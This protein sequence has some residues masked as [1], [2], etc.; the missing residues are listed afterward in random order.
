MLTRVFAVVAVIVPALFAGAQV[1]PPLNQT[2]ADL[3]GTMLN[4]WHD[5]AAKA[6]E[7]RYFKHFLPNAV[8]MGTDIKERWTAKEFREWAQPYFKRG[9]AW[10][11]TPHDRHIDFST[12]MQTGWFDELLDTPNL[13]TARGS[14]VVRFTGEEWKIAQYNLSVP[15]PNEILDKVVKMIREGP[16]AQGAPAP[17]P[18]RPAL[19]L[20][21]MTFNIRYANPDDGENRWENRR[22]FLA[23]VIR[24]GHYDVVG[25]QEALHA[26][27]SDLEHALPEFDRVGVGRDDGKQ[28]GEHAAIL[29]RKDRFR[30]L[31]EGTFWF[32]DTPQA[33]GS[34]AWG[35]NVTRVCTWARLAERHTPHGGEPRSFYIYNVHLDQESQP[36]REKSVTLLLDRIAARSVPTPVI[37]TGDFNAGEDNVIIQRMTGETGPQNQHPGA[38][39]L[40]V[41]SFRIAHPDEHTVGTFHDFRGT[42]HQ[43]GPKIDF[44]FVPRGTPVRSA[45]IIRDSE[46]GRYPSD[47]FAVDAHISLPGEG[48]E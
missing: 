42:N 27:L 38:R 22:E 5:A 13:G 47:H 16:H 30:V 19:D 21:V 3:V 20:A 28:A 26:Q 33:P 40:F 31:E 44:I 37:V 7:P 25:L 36:S 17:N 32:S 35:N 1:T 9:K 15:V 14:G 18:A 29:F 24:R 34:R 10:S 23:E 12:D 39:P 45:Q 43:D 41:D 48:A 2:H 4:D 46:H 6:D 11:F 8:F